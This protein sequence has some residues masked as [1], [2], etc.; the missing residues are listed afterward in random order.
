MLNISWAI[1]ID[2]SIKYLNATLIRKRGNP[3]SY[4]CEYNP[5][6]VKANLTG[7]KQIWFHYLIEAGYGSDLIEAANIPLAQRGINY[8]HVKITM[9]PPKPLDVKAKTTQVPPG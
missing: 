5:P 8:K 7:L 4:H 1:N 3:V 2:A 6:L 9:P